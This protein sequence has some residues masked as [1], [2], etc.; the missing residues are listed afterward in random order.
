MDINQLK[1]FWQSEEQMTFKGWD[2][3]YIAHRTSTQELPW[4][5]QTI[6]TSY[7]DR[8]ITMLDMGTGGG[9]FLVSLHPPAGTTFATESYPPNVELCMNTLPDHGIEVRQVFD[10]EKLPFEDSFFD[11]IINRHTSFSS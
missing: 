7:I 3:S 4:N 6:V 11:L 8:S 9:E 10:D 1:Q 5:Y 2:F